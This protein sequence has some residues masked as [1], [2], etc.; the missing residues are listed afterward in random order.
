MEP[1]SKPIKLSNSQKDVYELCP[2]KYYLYYVKKYRSVIQGSALLMGNAF[3]E[4]MNDLLISKDLN[5]AKEI[6]KT[7]WLTHKDKQIDYY[8]KDSLPDCSPYDSLLIKGLNCI[9][10][11]YENILPKI[12]NVIS[13]QEKVSLEASLAEGASEPD[14][15][16]GI[17]DFIGTIEH[18]G[19]EK[20]GIFDNKTTS[21]PYP[22]NSVVKKEQLPLYSYCR[23]EYEYQGYITVNK[24]TYETQIIVDQ[25]PLAR[26]LE[27]ID[28]FDDILHNIKCNNFPKNSKGCWAFG[29]KCIYYSHCH[30]G[31]KFTPDIYQEIK[32]E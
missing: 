25:I 18:E 12:K 23:D 24:H 13:I 16:T 6:Y 17:I 14:T 21:S 28:K 5:K 19:E 1:K 31:G 11:Y 15:I 20:T 10:A 9:E 2:Y 30:E 22:K 8:T 7:I 29:K 32:E 27:V 4:A 3:D 26:K